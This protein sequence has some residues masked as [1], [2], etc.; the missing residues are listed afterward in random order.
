MDDVEF[1]ASQLVRSR[2]RDA[3]PRAQQARS[4]Y[5]RGSRGYNY[6]TDVISEIKTQYR[7]RGYNPSQADFLKHASKLKMKRE[8][9]KALGQKMTADEFDYAVRLLYREKA[10]KKMRIVKN[11]K[12]PPKRWWKKCTRSVRKK[13]RGNEKKICG[14]LWYQKMSRKSKRKAVKKYEKNP[15]YKWLGKRRIAKWEKLAKKLGVSKVARSSRGFLT[16]YK[17]A[18]YDHRKLSEKWRKKRNAFVKRH[19]AQ[20]KKRGESLSKNGKPS[21]RHLALIMWA[22]SPRG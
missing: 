12:R 19:M 2:R 17:K 7:V 5:R 4:A 10:R 13:S 20:V 1:V 6:W 3:L 14:S 9:E 18:G 21:R 11:P 22:Y 8:L 16:A 15:R